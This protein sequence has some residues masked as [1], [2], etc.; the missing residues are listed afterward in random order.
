M[1]AV[2]GARSSCATVESDVGSRSGACTLILEKHSLAVGFCWP[3]PRLS[4]GPPDRDAAI[5]RSTGAVTVH[6]PPAST[7][8]GWVGRGASQHCAP[9]VARPE[10]NRREHKALGRSTQSSVLVIFQ[11]TF[12]VVAGHRDTTPGYRIR[13]ILGMNRASIGCV[14]R[15]SARELCPDARPD[16]PFLNRIASHS[17]HISAIARYGAAADRG[18]ARAGESAAHRSLF[19]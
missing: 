6:L 8:L 18:R 2:M 1:S 10:H 13:G 12:L 4:V 14:R 5:T 15:L 16:Q 7:V 11:L 17:P 19:R 3:P 9:I